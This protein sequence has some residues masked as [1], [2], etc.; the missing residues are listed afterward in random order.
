MFFKISWLKQTDIWPQKV[1]LLI[2]AQD[3]NILREILVRY[4]IVVLWIANYVWEPK[5]FWHIQFKFLY[6]WS[7]FNWYSSFEKAKDCYEFLVTILWFEVEYI[8]NLINPLTDEQVQIVIKKLKNDYQNL[9]SRSNV[10]TIDIKKN[11]KD[12]ANI[13]KF[14]ESINESIAESEDLISKAA[15]IVSP[16]IIKQLEDNINELKKLRMWS[17]LE[18]LVMLFETLLRNMEAVEIYYIDY[19]KK[20]EDNQVR[21]ELLTDLDIITEYDKYKKTKKIS[22]VSWFGWA[23]K[24]PDYVYYSFFG[25]IWFYIK[26]LFKEVT[27]KNDI[28]N[29]LYSSF[30]FFENLMIF[31]MIEMLLY[32]MYFIV[33]WEEKLVVYYFLWNI[34]LLWIVFYVFKFFRAKD[35]S[36]NIFLYGLILVFFY[37]LQRFI[38]INFAF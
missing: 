4:G 20:Q 24:T 22:K 32:Y 19:L 2:D 1:L 38:V 5:E 23:Y 8:N 17:N 34:W 33:N 36:T 11:L 26:L 29:L 6:E 16:M 30:S 18:K 3:E 14:K 7:L 13:K 28:S 25:K 21:D 27:L 15:W 9:N 37:L 31:M 35:I 10:S 12:D